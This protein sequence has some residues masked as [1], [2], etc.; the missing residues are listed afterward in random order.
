MAPVCRVSSP[1]TSTIL[2]T[3]TDLSPRLN[4]PSNRGGP[5]R[6]S[7]FP[8]KVPNELPDAGAEVGT[9][10][11][12]VGPWPDPNQHRH[13]RQ[14]RR[15]GRWELRLHCQRRW[16]GQLESGRWAEG[17]SRKRRTPRPRSWSRCAWPMPTC[18][19]SSPRRPSPC[20][21]P[22]VPPPSGPEGS[23]WCVAVASTPRPDGPPSR[24]YPEVTRPAVSGRPGDV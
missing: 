2:S 8:A 17:P 12:S 16:D 15:H 4:R 3:F 14:R 22:S 7:H 9:Y 18:P 5:A 13:E 21:C 20:S 11:V 19:P 23:S 24:T 6:S 1:R 10:S